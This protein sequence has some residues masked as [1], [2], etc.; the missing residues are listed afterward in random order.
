MKLKGSLSAHSLIRAQ[1]VHDTVTTPHPDGG[2]DGIVHW[3]ASFPEPLTLRRERLAI[4][5]CQRKPYCLNRGEVPAERKTGLS[6]FKSAENS[7]MMDCFQP[8]SIV[9]LWILRQ[10]NSPLR[11]IMKMAHVPVKLNHFYS[12]SDSGIKYAVL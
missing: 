5:S 9:R 6:P 3:L 4:T 7:G 12:I 1:P 8:Q 2:S 11:Q 10:S